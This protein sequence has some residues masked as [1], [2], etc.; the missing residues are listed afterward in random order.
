[1]ARQRTEP[2]EKAVKISQDLGI[3][4]VELRGKKLSREELAELA[5]CHPNSLGAI[6]R[7]E[8]CPSVE[9]LQN[10]ALALGMKTSTLLRKAGY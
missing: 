1:L 6:E 8:S 2:D 9:T 5:G 4:I 10:I 3:L 7:G